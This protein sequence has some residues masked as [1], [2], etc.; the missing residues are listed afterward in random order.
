MVCQTLW[1]ETW[2][3]SSV[4]RLVFNAAR[5]CVMAVAETSRSS[6]KSCASCTTRSTRRQRTPF[7]RC[8][9]VY[10]SNR[11]L[12]PNEYARAAPDLVANR[13]HFPDV[14]ALESQQTTSSGKLQTHSTT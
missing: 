11:A 5:C 14:F 1:E 4:H 2:V 3:N 7:S 12:A 6:G 8:A 13:N 9:G 10:A